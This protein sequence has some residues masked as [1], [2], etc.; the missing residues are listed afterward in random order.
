[1]SMRF[2]WAQ[3]SQF[4]RSSSDITDANFAVELTLARLRFAF[5]WVRERAASEKFFS[6]FP[7]QAASKSGFEQPVKTP[8]L[9]MMAKEKTNDN[10]LILNDSVDRPKNLTAL[11][12]LIVDL[13]SKV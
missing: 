5:N 2:A 12:H 7:V 6:Y 8:E 4:L 10:R 1:M 11:V 3:F 9:K 13:K